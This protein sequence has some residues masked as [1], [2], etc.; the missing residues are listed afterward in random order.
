MDFSL[1]TKLVIILH[2]HRILNYISDK[3]QTIKSLFSDKIQT[4][5]SFFVPLMV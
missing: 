5:K 4:I 2:I 1:P 3:I